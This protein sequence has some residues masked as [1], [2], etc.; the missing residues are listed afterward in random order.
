MTRRIFR[1]ILAVTLI[2]FLS[3]MMIIPSVFY[4]FFEN[5]INKELSAEVGV[6]AAGVE[7]YGVEFLHSFDEDVN[8]V[9]SDADGNE[10][11]KTGNWH[12]EDGFL[13]ENT[14]VES[15]LDDGSTIAITKIY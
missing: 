5:E 7:K 15:V 2:A 4:S 11:Y 10:L 6:I 1:S 9:Y 8:I 13:L 3:V 14:T 12:S